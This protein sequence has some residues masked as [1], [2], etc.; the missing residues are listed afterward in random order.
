MN[1]R[2]KCRIFVAVVL[3]VAAAVLGRQMSRHDDRPENNL[4]GNTGREE[5]RQS[6]ALEDGAEVEVRGIN[7][8]V[9]VKTAE[10]ATAEVHITRTADNN[11]ALAHGRIVVEHTPSR[12]VVRGESNGKGGFW[13]K[14]WGAGS[15]RHQI[16]L[17]VPR[18]VELEAKGVNGPV[19]IGEVDG[20]VTV[21]GVNGR[22][23][24]AQSIGRSELKGING[25]VKVAVARI[26]PGGMEV[27][28]VNG[29]V[30][31]ELREQ[32]NA[33]I[34]VR[35]LNGSFALDLPNVTMQEREDRSNMRARLGG[36]GVPVEITGVNG[37]VRFESSAPATGAAQPVP[38][39]APVVVTVPDA[40]LPPL[41]PARDNR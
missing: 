32:L 10:T 19:T 40:P 39:V 26:G 12:L 9:E 17:V 28:G 37:S 14:L 23:E 21:N 38:Q 34:S 3:V 4:L 15:V 33:D 30:E 35:G 27:Q 5:T 25:A 41:P 24:V 18:R 2:M 11:D 31:I 20:S 36:G 13:N 1:C 29:R 6:Y 8:S 22:V 7:G 16:V